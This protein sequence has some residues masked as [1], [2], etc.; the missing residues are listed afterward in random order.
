[1]NQ[2]KIVYFIGAGASMAIHP[3]IP[4][5][6]MFPKMKQLLQDKWDQL[7]KLLSE[8]GFKDSPGEE[9]VFLYRKNSEKS[10]VQHRVDGIEM[11]LQRLIEISETGNEDQIKA[12]ESAYEL[13][14]EF[15]SHFLSIWIIPLLRIAKI[16]LTIY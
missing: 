15:L 11:L 4:G 5:M 14:K 1:M 9:A 3:E 8:A 12:T 13:I 6:N 10:T 2:I 16:I 7:R